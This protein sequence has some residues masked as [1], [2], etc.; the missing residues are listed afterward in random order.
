M[1]LARLLRHCVAALLLLGSA[2]AWSH[3]SMPASLLLN[4]TTEHSFDVLWRIPQTQGAAPEIG[5]VFP[6]DCT[7]LTSPVERAAPGAKL[8]QWQI[9]CSRGLRSD[10]SIAFDGLAVTLIDVLVR[11]SYLDGSGEALVARPRTP[12]V[13]LDASRSQGL[14][15]SAYFGLGVAHILGGTDHLLFVLCLIL[16]VP[17]LRGLLKTVTAFTLAHS[18]TMALAFVGLVS[19]PSIVVEPLIALTIVYV[20][21]ENVLT[22]NV[23][24]R[25]VLTGL[26]GLVH[27]LGFVGALKTITVSR[28]ELVLSLVSFNAGVEVGQLLVIAIAVPALLFLRSRPWN[29][30][31][32]R[33]FSAGVAALGSFWLVQR[34]LG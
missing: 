22:P 25:W 27:G 17:S 9:R 32:C 21:I 3:E 33:G 30:K 10:A 1:T 19:L 24:R 11:V 23:G 20:A 12:R 28:D 13:M 16:L 7:A 31:F 8:L 26:F 29:R 5:P 4:E 2:A 6:A 18:L 14:E 34:V 15:V